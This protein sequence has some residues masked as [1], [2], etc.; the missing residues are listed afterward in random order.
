MLLARDTIPKRSSLMGKCNKNEALGGKGER[1]A[2]YTK[3]KS[4]GN[5]SSSHMNYF[6]IFHS[7]LVK[8]DRAGRDGTRDGAEAVGT[9]KARTTPYQFHFTMFLPPSLLYASK[10]RKSENPEAKSQTKESWQGSNLTA[11]G[12][13]LGGKRLHFS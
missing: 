9:G 5:I 4:G 2:L 11:P 12:A 10:E 6:V 7:T 3:P 1:G 13:P 8:N